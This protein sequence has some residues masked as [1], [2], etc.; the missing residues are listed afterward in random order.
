VI[1]ADLAGGA[2]RLAG[3]MGFVGRMTIAGDAAVDVDATLVVTFD[4]PDH[5]GAGFYV[6]QNGG[7]LHETNP[8][9]QGYEIY[10]EGD[11]VQTLSVWREVGGNEFVV[12][13][14]MDPIPTGLEPGVAYALRLQCV[15]AGAVTEL[16]VKAWPADEAEPAA[17]QLETTDATP[18]LQNIA[19]GFA[20]DVYNYFGTNDIYVDDIVVFAA[21]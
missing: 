3:A 16:R 17:W 13:S 19:G 8:P 18:Q 15:Q 9:G 5:Q 2:G 21:Q 1:A 20:V 4:D 14:V 7:A 12:A 6:R 11:V 10:L